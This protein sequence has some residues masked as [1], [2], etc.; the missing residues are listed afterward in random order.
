MAENRALMTLDVGCAD[1]RRYSTER[2]PG[3]AVLRMRRQDTPHIL[4]LVGQL[5]PRFSA[6]PLP[7]HLW[8]VEEGRL[9]VRS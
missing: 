7:F 3:L 1:I 6:E 5:L 2:S 4:D 8:I 9:R